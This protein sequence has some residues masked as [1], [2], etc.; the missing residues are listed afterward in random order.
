VVDD[1]DFV[2]TGA[3]TPL[4]ADFSSTVDFRCFGI[5]IRYR[6]HS[7]SGW[8]SIGDHCQTGSM[9]WLEDLGSGKRKDRHVDSVVTWDFD[10]ENV[11]R[12]SIRGIYRY[13]TNAG[14]SL[15][16]PHSYCTEEFI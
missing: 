9:D 1:A 4:L 5:I 12:E 2:C 15:R 11:P 6:L 10:L 7:L 3:L 13:N 14:D 8:W 16:S